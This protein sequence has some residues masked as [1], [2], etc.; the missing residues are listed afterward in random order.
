[1]SFLP[2][3][4]P[5]AI[6]GSI[7]SAAMADP[8]LVTPANFALA[9][10]E[11]YIAGVIAR[12]GMGR[13]AHVRELASA[14]RPLVVRPNRDTL[15]STAVLDLAAGP[16]TI[17][18]PQAGTRYFSLMVISADHHV[19]LIRHGGGT[20]RID[21][22]TVGSRYALVGL[23]IF[24]DPTRSGD[25]EAA[26]QLQD[27]VRL[28]QP[29]GPGQFVPTEWDAASHGK[30]RSALLAL[31]ETLPNLNQ[32]FGTARQVDPVA[33]LVGTAMAWGGLPR[34]EAT[35]LNVAPARND[36][37][38]AYQLKLGSVPVDAFWSITVYDRDGRLIANPQG[39][40]SLN[41]VSASYDADRSVT[42]QF[43]RCAAQQANCL[44]VTPGWNYMVRLY[45]PRSEILDGRWIFPAA[46][47]LEN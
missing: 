46:T 22:K 4:L 7:A 13:F 26:H 44:P 40:H 42:V 47:P 34:T 24:V 2:W 3:L 37:G 41:N 38:T 39:I 27:A 19:P 25:I 11:H 17:R 28:E 16:A 30:V 20:Y 6:A 23:R 21:R 35:Y 43:G 9:E 5:A 15:Y 14:E 31:G 1:M 8:V 18:L 36:A 29:G 33:H 32:A 10:T 12:G 45:R